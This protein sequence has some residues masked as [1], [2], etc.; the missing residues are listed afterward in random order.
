MAKA[1]ILCAICVNVFPEHSSQTKGVAEA[2][3]L[4]DPRTTEPLIRLSSFRF[5]TKARAMSR[6]VLRGYLLQKVV[7]AH[8]IQFA[9]RV[10]AFD[11]VHTN[12]GEHVKVFFEDGS[13]EVGDVLIAADGSKSLVGH[14]C[15]YFSKPTPESST[16]RSAIKSA[17]TI[18]HKY[19]GDII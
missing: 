19:T 11:I 1:S 6:R 14:G 13:H 7:A 12:D 15:L 16:F 5:Y 17:W 4:M 3:T 10:V 9:K 8:S 18:V 2:P